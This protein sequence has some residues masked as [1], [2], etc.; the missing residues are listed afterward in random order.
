MLSLAIGD[1]VADDEGSVL[2]EFHANGVSVE[3]V[4]S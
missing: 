1:P 2:T 4:R 3:Q